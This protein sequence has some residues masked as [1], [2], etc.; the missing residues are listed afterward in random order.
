MNLLSIVELY[1]KTDIIEKG[2]L[3]IARYLDNKHSEI[4]GVT[5]IDDSKKL[6]FTYKDY[7]E[8]TED[9]LY[10][11]VNGLSM[12]IENPIYNKYGEDVLLKDFRDLY[13]NV[14]FD[15]IDNNY[16]IYTDSKEYVNTFTTEQLLLFDKS[17]FYN[18]TI[19]E[20]IS[21]LQTLYDFIY[22]MD[23]IDFY[24]LHDLMTINYDKTSI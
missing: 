17:I 7:L 8:D 3:R 12:E 11:N 1:N 14:F 15:L 2:V 21:Q 22:N 4:I 13:K 5:W 19:D 16:I 6:K 18:I 9:D 23:Y 24:R 20:D 10:I